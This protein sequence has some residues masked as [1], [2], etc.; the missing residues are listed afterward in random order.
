LVTV[1]T[2]SSHIGI[3]AVMGNADAL[4]LHDVFLAAGTCLL[5]IAFFFLLFS[6]LKIAAFDEQTATAQGASPKLLSTLL[7]LMT[8]LTLTC[9]FRAVGVILVLALLVAPPIAMR[10]WTER[11]STLILLAAL[12]G[13]LSSIVAVAFSR[14]MVS[15]HQIPLSTGGC[16]TVATGLLLVLSLTF[17]KIRS[18][19]IS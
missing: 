9:A 6:R 7:L 19:M 16:A 8:A 11:L 5:N 17:R 15:V 4:H 13:A 3:E 2:R 18:L 1:F 10:P 12:G 14:H